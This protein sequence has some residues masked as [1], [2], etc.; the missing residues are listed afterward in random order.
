LNAINSRYERYAFTGTAPLGAS[1]D[2]AIASAA[3]DAIIGAITVGS[4]SFPGFG[5]P[6]S[7]AAA[8]TQVDGQYLQ[9]LSA[10]PDGLAK[11]DGIAVGQVAAAAIL[12]LRKNDHATDLVSYTPG[13]KPG[14]W[15]PTP[16]PIPSDPLGAKDLLPA[17]VPGWGLVTPFVLR[18]SLQFEP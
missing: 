8:V 16:N 13:A 15:Q 4:L 12:Q 6:Q 7:Q 9:F 18:R 1:A 5:T 3:R 14:D 10:I 17:A 2:A 11:S